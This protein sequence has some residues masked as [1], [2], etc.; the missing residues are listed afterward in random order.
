MSRRRPRTR[1]AAVAIAALALLALLAGCGSSNNAK[2]TTAT[3]SATTPAPTVTAGTSPTTGPTA[4]LAGAA[5]DWPTYHQDLARRGVI[6]QGPN[7]DALKQHWA[8]P[9]LDGLVYAE[10]LVVGDLVIAATEGDSVYALH[11]DNGQIAWRS[12]LGRP[13]RANQLPCGN[14]DP[15]GITGTPVV[16]TGSKTVYVVAFVQPGR[17]ELVALDLAT[18]DV[19]SRRPA[20]P[21]DSPLV[22]QER[23]AL[24]IANGFVYVPYGGLFGD[25]GQYHGWVVAS[26][27][28]GS[29]PL[30]SFQVPVA[31][32][33]GLWAPPGPSVDEQGNLYVALGNADP[34][35][36]TNYGNSVL[37]VTP[38]LKLADAFIDPDTEA[39][40]RGDVDLGSLSPALLDGGLAFQAG[41]AGKGYLLNT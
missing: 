18:G 1:A 33:G 34:E 38:D 5:A 17:H 21:S 23:G 29:G 14:V 10:P 7:P 4:P 20:D 9:Q 22:L 25:C 30:T 13:M 8:S 26:R 19:K 16:D 2:K 37:R 35:P 3:T 41:K 11:K 12:Q 32:E 40:N 6:G 31:R 36:G 39:L 24:T 28:D 27:L 15:S